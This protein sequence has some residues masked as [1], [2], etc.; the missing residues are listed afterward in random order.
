MDAYSIY[1][2]VL[3]QVLRHFLTLLSGGL[4][5]WGITTEQQN[6]LIETTIYLL[7]PI[8]VALFVQIW[9]YLSKRY[10]PLLLEKAFHT[11]PASGVTL[12]DLKAEAKAEVSANAIIPSLPGS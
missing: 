5:A 1:T 11:S 7:V 6:T 4:I 8:I 2:A 9:S 10:L 3:G 12:T